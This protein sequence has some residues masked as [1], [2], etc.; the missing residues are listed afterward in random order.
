MSHQHPSETE[1]YAVFKCHV[2]GHIL[3][4]KLFYAILTKVT[5]RH[6]I[7]L[8]DNAIYYIVLKYRAVDTG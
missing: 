3:L 8:S 2:N 6:F 4:E 5:F 7:N 1:S